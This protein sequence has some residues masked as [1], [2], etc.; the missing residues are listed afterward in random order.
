MAKGGI[1]AQL[2]R[3]VAIRADPTTPDALAELAKALA[4]KTNLAAAK[5]A[6]IVAQ[7]R[8]VQ[9]EKPLVDAFGVFV[10]GADKG[11]AAKTSIA[12]ALAALETR[13][14]EEVFIVGA[15]HVQ[16]EPVWGGS[17]DAAIELRCVSCVALVNLRSR[18][19]LASL[20]HLL[21]DKDAGARAAAVRAL[22]ALGGD[23]AEALIQFKM[24]D[25]D[26][27]ANVVGECFTATIALTRS[28]EAVEPFLDSADQ[29]LR[30]SAALAIGESRL[31][32]AFEALRK[33]WEKQIVHRFGD[34]LLLAIA[35]T[36]QPEALEL[37]LSVVAKADEKAAADAV[38]AMSMYRGDDA[39]RSKIRAAARERGGEVL[40][41]FDEHF[42][43]DDSER[44]HR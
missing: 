19:A 41:A 23:G 26:K 13:G 17:A 14:A 18:Q 8:L 24:L 33:R 2:D 6:D 21:A 1:D 34:P 43:A 36:R 42:S 32:A 20:V 29:D 37:L 10:R 15:R 4:S 11:C 7:H 28:I 31:P 35:L 9:F 5:A 39:V 16:L 30:E 44:N 12:K 22:A 25:G 27:D 40:A 38:G 3:L